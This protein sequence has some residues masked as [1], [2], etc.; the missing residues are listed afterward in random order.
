MVITVWLRRHSRDNQIR[1]ARKD[2]DCSC[3]RSIK[4]QRFPDLQTARL[5]L[6]VL[7]KAASES[8]DVFPG[9][10]HLGL[11]LYLTAEH[12]SVAENR[13]GLH[14]NCA[15]AEV[16]FPSFGKAGCL[17]HQ[18]EIRLE[19]RNANRK[20][21]K[22]HGIASLALN[23]ILQLEHLPTDLALRAQIER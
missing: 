4:S 17:V 15:A 1:V 8:V 9:S 23:R 18:S 5:L 14:A 13:C 16:C 7:F 19:G 12:H 6:K 20:I 10:F 21:T 22:P 3:K 11:E 2:S